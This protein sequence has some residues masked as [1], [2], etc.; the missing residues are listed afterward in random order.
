MRPIRCWDLIG[1]PN[2]AQGRAEFLEAVY[3]YLLLAGN[4]YVE[5]VPGLGQPCRA[6]CM[7]CGRTG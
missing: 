1:T 3:G 4:A 6:S 2:G 7:C 5:A